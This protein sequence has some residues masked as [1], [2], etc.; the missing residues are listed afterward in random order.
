[1]FCVQC[2]FTNLLYPS[3]RT[4]IVHAPAPSR[5]LTPLPGYHSDGFRPSTP[6][7]GM[8]SLVLSRLC[9]LFFCGSNIAPFLMQGDLHADIKTITD[10]FFVPGPIVDFLDAFVRGQ[11]ALPVTSGRI[12]GLPR[13]WRR[14][15]GNAPTTLRI[16]RSLNVKGHPVP[17]GMSSL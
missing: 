2:T 10:K 7:S 17:A 11:G 16:C 5:S 9:P 3:N 6:L 4:D 13:A 12:Q 8:S 1:M 15:F 14:G